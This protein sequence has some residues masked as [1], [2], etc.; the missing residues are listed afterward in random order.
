[1]GPR[2]SVEWLWKSSCIWVWCMKSSVAFGCLRKQY[3]LPGSVRW[4]QRQ[5]WS[6]GDC[7]GGAPE[8]KGFNHPWVDPSGYEGC[9]RKGIWV[10]VETS[11]LGGSQVLG[12]VSPEVPL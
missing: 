1:M 10:L 9:P 8:T 11:I 12:P 3:V 6:L 4:Y 5:G 2:V 7:D